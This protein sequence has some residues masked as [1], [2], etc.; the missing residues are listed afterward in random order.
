[1]FRRMLFALTVVTLL[2]ALCASSAFAANHYVVAN[3]DT[4]TNTV[5]VFQV[6]GISLVPLTTVEAT[7]KRY[8]P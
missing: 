2:A 1:M 6:S 3:N 5:S 8:V 7:W 4:S